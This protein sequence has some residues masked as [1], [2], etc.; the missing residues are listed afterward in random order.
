MKIRRGRA[1]VTGELSTAPL[2][3]VKWEDAGTEATIRKSGDLP[4]AFGNPILF[5]LKRCRR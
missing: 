3:Q 5:A 2:F 1:T 4:Q